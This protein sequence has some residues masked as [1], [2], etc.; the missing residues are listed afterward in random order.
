MGKKLLYTKEE[1][2][3]HLLKLLPESDFILESYAGTERPC[4][5]TCNICKRS[6]EYT[7]AAKIARRARR[8]NKNVCRYCEKN[9]WTARQQAAK[10]KALYLLNK[11]QTIEAVTPV[12]SWASRENNLWLCK[13][14]GHTFSRSPQVM[15]TQDGLYCP[16]CETHPFEYSLDEIQVRAEELWG[17]EYSFLNV[18]KLKNKNGSK[19]VLVCHNKC[20]FKYSVNL[21]NFLHGQGCP[22][23]KSSHGERKVRR[24]LQQH[25]FL[26]L[27]QKSIKVN[28]SYLKLDFYL[29]NNGKKFAIEYNGI[30]HYQPVA[31]FNGEQGFAAQQKRDNL[32]KEYCLNNNIEL[33]IIPYNDESLLNSEE[34]AQRLNN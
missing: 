9:N 13:K 25:N 10:N 18:D 23:C 3:Q 22:K 2:Y 6:Y 33:I 11:K 7:E 16:W 34:L 29:E 1:Y 28:N 5:I 27:E 31:Y 15:F 12:I 32:K 14:C 20:G 17:N 4:R 26:F 30:Q 19:R 8:G 24:Y 21:W